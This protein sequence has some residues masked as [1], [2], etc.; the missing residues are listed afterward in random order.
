MRAILSQF[1]RIY[2]DH[3]AGDKDFSGQERRL[4]EAN[5]KLM[6]A[7]DDLVRSSVHLNDVLLANGFKLDKSDLH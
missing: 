3:G 2:A 5:A 1:R 7:S 4:R 6:Q